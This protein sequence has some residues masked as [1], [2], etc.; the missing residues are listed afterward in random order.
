MSGSTRFLEIDFLVLT[1]FPRGRFLIVYSTS[2]RNLRSNPGAGRYRVVG[3]HARK[4]FASAQRKEAMTRSGSSSTNSTACSTELQQR[5]VALQ[6]AH[7]NLEKRV[8]ERTSYLNAL[9]QNSP[10]GILV[11]DSEQNV[12]LCNSAFEKLFERSRE[13]I[14]G[15]TSRQFV[16]RC[17]A[18]A[19]RSPNGP[20]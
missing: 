11:V 20:E 17:R 10:L 4:L 6:R 9:I 1:G 5:D 15:K 12:Q 13:E 7:D 18:L 8:A 3:L 14:I 16:R 19:G 2:A